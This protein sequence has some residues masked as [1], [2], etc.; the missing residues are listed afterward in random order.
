MAYNNYTPNYFYP[1]YPQNTTIQN[2]G[3]VSVRSEAEARNYPVAPGN[4][5]TFFSETERACYTKTCTNQIDPPIFEKYKL[6][7]EEMPVNA[8]VSVQD[9]PQGKDTAYALKSDVEAICAEIEAIK[10]RLEKPEPKRAVKKK[11]E[12]DE[13]V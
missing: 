1:N 6:I 11:E 12:A 8:S 7:K 2:G 3:L 13:N 4:S 10:A 9:A 5:V